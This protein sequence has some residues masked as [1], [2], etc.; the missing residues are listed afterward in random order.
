MT[1]GSSSARRRLRRCSSWSSANEHGPVFGQSSAGSP[2]PR[3]RSTIAQ[4]VQDAI[5]Q[6]GA[7]VQAVAR[8]GWGLNL[9]LLASAS[10]AIAGVVWVALGED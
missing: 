10:L 9:T 7:L 1:V 2:E 5:D 4:N 3:F 6:G 8:V